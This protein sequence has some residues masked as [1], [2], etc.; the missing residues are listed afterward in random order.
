MA[1]TTLTDKKLLSGL[2]DRDKTAIKYLYTAYWPMILHFVL[3]N[4]G[5]EADAK[6]LFQ[7]GVLDFLEQVWK[8]DLVLTCTLKTYLYSICKYKWLN[9]LRQKVPVV[10]IEDYDDP[11]EV[12]PVF[13]KA[14]LSL[15]DGKELVSAVISLGEPCKSVLIGFYY[16]GLSMEQIAAKLDYK[17][18]QVVKQQKFRCKERLKQ[19]LTK[20]MKTGWS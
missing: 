2:Y 20:F 15:P 13:D 18:A 16:E 12:L 7:E 19:I 11:G 6:D 9:R 4:N 3:V 14:D 8:G 1:G 17:S 10:D 5:T